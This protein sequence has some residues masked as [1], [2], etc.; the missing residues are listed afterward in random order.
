MSVTNISGLVS[1]MDTSAIIDAM[2]G[3]K[4]IQINKLKGQKS[5]IDS[6]ISKIGTIK[7]AMTELTTFLEDFKTD[8]EVL[9]FAG[10]TTDEDVMT[11][12]V[13]GGALPGSYEL[14]VGQLANLEKDRSQA[15][16]ATTDAVK[17]GSL[18]LTVK[19]EDAVTIDLT[20]GMTLSEVA[21][22]VNAS[23]AEV[24]ASI[25]NDGT[26]SYLQISAKETGHVIGADPNDAI[27]IEE[28]YTG[29][30]GGMLNL[31]QVT[32]AANSQF[33]LDGLPVE[34]TTNN[35]S[36]VLSGV[37]LE[38]KE[39]G[40]AYITVEPDKAATKENLEAFVAM[41]N[42]AFIPVSRELKV[43][44]DTDYG[45]SL[46]GDSSIRRLKLALQT[47]VGKTVSGTSGSWDALSE[48]GIEL[49]PTGKLSI[50]SDKLDDAL[51]KDISGIAD[52][53]S[54]ED[55]GISDRLINIMEPYIED[56][57]GVFKGKVDSYNDRIDL[58]DDEIEDQRWRIDKM[59]MRLTMQFAN[60][61]MAVQ[62]FN[63]QG[64]ALAGLM[65]A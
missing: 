58:I 2:K 40:S 50:D 20:E 63:S 28:N 3:V 38:L 46:A 15:F 41:F 27:I 33:M 39:L 36:D 18:T 59:V 17:A 9:E 43:T 34:Q 25:I 1:G 19:E 60:M 57:E 6:K 48:I 16:T 11:V 47:N 8:D 7:S 24:F 32:T 61:E 21:D 53:F 10:T 12:S 5:D 26:Y 13:G 29:A 56:L 31:T 23:D 52:L 22:A 14:Q 55:E 44:E 37:T 51:D 30:T 45:S 42:E 49:D 64:G 65:A 35:V 62:N 4:E 54:L